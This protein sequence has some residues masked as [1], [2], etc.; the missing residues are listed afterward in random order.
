MTALREHRECEWQ[1][2]TQMVEGAD[3]KFRLPE[4]R[5]TG[6]P[7]MFTLEASPAAGPRRL[8]SGSPGRA[9]AEGRNRSEPTA[10]ISPGSTDRD[11]AVHA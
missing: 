7:L 1:A 9:S 5:P 4:A 8:G 2:L 11:R 6:C 10:L 3:G